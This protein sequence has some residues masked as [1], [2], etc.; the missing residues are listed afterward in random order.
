MEH[1]TAY[2]PL[3]RMFIILV[4]QTIFARSWAPWVRCVCLII[5]LFVLVVAGQVI[6][7]GMPL[8]L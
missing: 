4:G 6:I 1:T 8:P 7:F 5:I 3:L 2:T